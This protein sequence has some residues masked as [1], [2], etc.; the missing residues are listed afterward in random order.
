MEFFKQEVTQGQINTINLGYSTD[1]YHQ[2][3]VMV[4]LK[5]VSEAIA[6]TLAEDQRVQLFN[7]NPVQFTQPGQ[8][9]YVQVQKK[10]KLKSIKNYWKKISSRLYHRYSTMGKHI[11]R[12]SERSTPKQHPLKNHPQSLA[13]S[14]VLCLKVRRV[15][16]GIWPRI[17]TPS[18]LSTATVSLHFRGILVDVGFL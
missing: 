5:P 12:H 14:V 10:K 13:K 1:G 9:Q 4:E 16:P 11:S 8:I 3:P 2:L 7:I 18:K 6:S 17:R 15:C